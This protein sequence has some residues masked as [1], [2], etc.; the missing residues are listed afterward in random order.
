MV[1]A[2]TR[3]ST[4]RF[5]LAAQAAQFVIFKHAKKFRLRGHRHLADFVEKKSS[6]FGKFEATGATLKRASESAFFVSEDFA[7]DQSL[8][9]GC[10]I[11]RDEGLAAARAHVVNRAGD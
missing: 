11:D 1:A 9:N 3:T 8:W 10:A 7:L 4:D 2:R 6:S 5:N